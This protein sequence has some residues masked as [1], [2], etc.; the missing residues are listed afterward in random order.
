MSNTD[1]TVHAKAVNIARRLSVQNEN[2]L[3]QEP[4]YDTEDDFDKYTKD[5][6]KDIAA[7]IVHPK[8]LPSACTRF[9]DIIHDLEKKDKDTAHPTQWLS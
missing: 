2:D 7:H 9:S 8:H 5:V 3:M 4:F 6:C 1:I